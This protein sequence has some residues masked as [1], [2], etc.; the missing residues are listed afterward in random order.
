MTRSLNRLTAAVLIG[1]L[2]VAVSLTYWSVFG[3]N[4]LLARDDNPR[5]VEAEQILQ[6][7]TIYDR[8]GMVLAQSVADGQSPSGKVLSRRDYPQ[9]DALSAVGYYSLRY[10]VGGV[11]EAFDSTLRGD[12]LPDAALQDAAEALL[13][14]PQ[15]GSDLRLT[16]DLPL[17]SVVV[18]ALKPY[19]GAVIALDVPSGAV[20][21]M[22]SA[23]T[24]DPNI[25]DSAFKA[26]QADPSAPLLNRVTQ[27]V[28]QPGG[29]LETVILAGLLTNKTALDTPI[30]GLDSTLQLN[31]LSLIC[32][33]NG[34]SPTLQNAYA[35]T[36]PQPFAQA[37][38]D[39]RNAIQQAID[40]FGLLHP[41]ILAHFRTQ[42]GKLPPSLTSY[43]DDKVLLEM[44]GAGQGALTVTP[45]QMALVAATIANHG[46]GISP[47][48]ADATRAPGTQIWQPLD[49][50]NDQ[51]AVTS[52]DTAN[53]IRLAMRAAVTDGSAH[54]ADQAGLTVYGHASFAYTGASKNGASWFIG[55]IDRPNGGSIALAVV[56][57]NTQDPT[58]AARI[59]GVVLHAAS[60]L[61][62][63]PL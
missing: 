12:A 36:C 3:S 5:R 20:R 48:I 26:L 51:P 41:P 1:F 52:Q 32:T 21:A 13:H 8:A 18:A 46:N 58:I 11:E 42:T 50:P 34:A 60:S 55:F 35:H 53:A 49:L 38:Y 6:R 17:Q 47:Y 23:P 59:G 45:L 28:Y 19:R 33:L 56:I 2:A 9:P 39:Q 14:R 37:A 63:T 43:P 61:K 62:E 10:S 44:Q 24:Y 22:V 27:G 30:S 4:Q 54:A 25:L 57:E 31:G 16:L 7:G 15:V 29:A 40:A